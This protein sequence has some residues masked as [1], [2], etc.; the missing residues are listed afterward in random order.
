M[1]SIDS[2]FVIFGLNNWK[3]FNNLDV[4]NLMDLNVHLS[5]PYFFNKKNSFESRFLYLF[6]NK[7]NSTAD[8]F[9]YLGYQIL[10][11]F[12]SDIKIYK[13]YPKKF[14]S[15]YLNSTSPLFH[16]KDFDLELIK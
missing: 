2:S 15:G 11:R 14:K 3:D 7:Y 13:F 1:G 9:A 5:D 6:E 4:Q 16:Y 12:C 10:L 8:R